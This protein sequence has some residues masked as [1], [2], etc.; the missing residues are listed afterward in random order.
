MSGIISIIIPFE[1]DGAL[2]TVLIQSIEESSRLLNYLKHE[3][4]QL[5]ERLYAVKAITN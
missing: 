3:R 1:R 2:Q 4:E 5:K